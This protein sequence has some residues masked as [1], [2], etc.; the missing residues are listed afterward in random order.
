MIRK[1]SIPAQSN[2]RW[3][4]SYADL[5]TLLLAFFVVLFAASQSKSDGDPSSALRHALGG[6]THADRT[7]PLATTSAGSMT[8]T[9]A[10]AAEVQMT[11]RLQQLLRKE[12]ERG[13]LSVYE[14]DDAVVISLREAGFYRVG[15]ATVDAASDGILHRIAVEL[16]SSSCAIR[17]EGYTDA[18]PIQTAEFPSNWELSTGRATLLVRRFVEQEGIAPTRLSA[19][20]YAEYHPVAS[21]STETERSRN[22]RVD[23][24]LVNT[25]A[26]PSHIS[27]TDAPR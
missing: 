15:S 21:D 13:V 8:D 7:L 20:G 27:K 26:G 14:R 25:P 4:V 11:S 17:I 5:L 9:G 22:R 1:S 24:V 3:L 2:H 16:R 10:H 6:F 23:I 12:I 19:A 18:T